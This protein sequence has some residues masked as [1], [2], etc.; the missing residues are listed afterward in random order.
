MGH[1]LRRFFCSNISFDDNVLTY[2]KLIWQQWIDNKS[3]TSKPKPKNSIS[4]D[5]PLNFLKN[6]LRY[7][8]N[9][10]LYNSIKIPTLP[11]LSFLTSMQNIST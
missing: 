11:L 9:G 6:T 7:I 2:K 5:K 10:T 8:R 4:I 3:T 1:S